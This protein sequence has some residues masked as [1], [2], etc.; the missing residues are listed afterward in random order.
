MFTPARGRAAVRW[1]AFLPATIFAARL[2]AKAKE[3]SP[4]PLKRARYALE[5]AAVAAF[6][7]SIRLLPRPVVLLLARGLGDAAYLLLRHDRRVALANLDIALKGEI[8]PRDKR[9]MA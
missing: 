4:S 9:R 6:A 1:I 7:A 3:R 5:F 2:G 8:A